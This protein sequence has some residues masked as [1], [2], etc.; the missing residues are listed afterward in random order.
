MKIK[1]RPV[2]TILGIEY[3][4]VISKWFG[5][6]NR[7]YAQYHTQDFAEVMAYNLAKDCKTN[8]VKTN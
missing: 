6:H 5:L 2:D 7:I 1:V 3:A 4:I 8:F